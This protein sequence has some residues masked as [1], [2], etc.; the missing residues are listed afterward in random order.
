MFSSKGLLESV[1]FGENTRH[2]NNEFH[3]ENFDERW[4]FH[5][6]NVMIVALA[7]LAYVST[8]ALWQKLNKSTLKTAR[9]SNISIYWTCISLPHFIILVDLE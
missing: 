7:F 4:I 6:T 5:Y 3:I 8:H 9:Y 2:R 1:E